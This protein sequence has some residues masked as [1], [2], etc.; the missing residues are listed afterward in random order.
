MYFYFRSIC[1]SKFKNVIFPCHFVSTTWLNR[2][3]TGRLA[4]LG[5]DLKSI[6]R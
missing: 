3:F 4:V 5:Y 2:D 1:L 6:F